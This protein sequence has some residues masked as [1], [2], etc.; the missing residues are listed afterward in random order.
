V[1][2]DSVAS[3]YVLGLS[4]LN[5]TYNDGI[6]VMLVTYWGLYLPMAFTLDR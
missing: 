3:L 6:Y 4:Q 1:F 5:Y 2:N